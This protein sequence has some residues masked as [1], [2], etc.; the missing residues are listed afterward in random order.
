MI[1]VLEVFR[2]PMANGG[3]ESFL[4]NMYRNMD[5]GQVQLD[6][7]TPFTCDNPDLK[8]EIE[9]MGG[10]VFTPGAAGLP[11]ALHLRQSGPEGGN[12]VHGWEGVHL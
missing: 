5:R 8:A 11:D 1:R 4:M 9:S 6:F 10:K 2:E 7:L 3:Q 12:R